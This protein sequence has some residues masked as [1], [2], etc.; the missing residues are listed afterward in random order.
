MAGDLKQ[1]IYAEEDHVATLTLNR[2][3]ILNSMDEQMTGEIISVIEKLRRPGRLRALVIASTGRCFS[4]GGNFDEIQRL[5]DDYDARMDAYDNGRRVIHGMAEIA[6]PVIVALQGDVYGLGTSLALSADIIVASRN[7]RIGDPHVKV[8]L[9]A[10]DGGTLVWPAAFGLLKSKRHLLTGDPIG[11]EEAHR[12]G[13]VSELVDDPEQVLPLAR[14]LA[15]KV[16]A[17]PPVAVQYTKRALNHSMQRAALDH[18][19]FAMALEQYAMT[20]DDLKEALA[21]LKEKRKPSFTNR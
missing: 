8:G 12:L 16:A 21:A 4:A 13:A 17:L 20:T 14:E 19:E 15:A 1:V 6:V 5:I 9:V 11:A 3:D 2:P 10:G 7:V 18:F